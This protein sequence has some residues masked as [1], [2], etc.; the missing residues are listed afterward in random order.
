MTPARIPTLCALAVT[1]LVLQGCIVAVDPQAQPASS[2]APVTGQTNCALLGGCDMSVPRKPQ[3]NCYFNADC[4]GGGIGLRVCIVNPADCTANRQPSG[5]I[6]DGLCTF[7]W[8]AS[9][10]DD[11]ERR[12]SSEAF[13]AHFAALQDAAQRGGAINGSAIDAARAL[14]PGRPGEAM[15]TLAGSLALL[16]VGRA[17]YNIDHPHKRGHYH[18]PG[19]NDQV[20]GTLSYGLARIDAAGAPEQAVMSLVGSAV[21]RFLINLDLDGLRA[22]LAT[23]ATVAPGYGGYGGCQHPHPAIDHHKFDYA[24]QYD[25]LATQ[26]IHTVEP[27]ASLITDEG[28]PAQAH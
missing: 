28:K 11:G 13:A 6:N 10:Q 5:K 1:L 26:V 8:W 20:P 7:F 25:C 2:V 4:I 15:E 14:L 24:N 9:L 18:Y 21:T 17:E 16:I 19:R 12:R 22:T 23:V 3:C 27:L